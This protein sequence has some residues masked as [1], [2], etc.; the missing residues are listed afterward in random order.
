LRNNILVLGS[1]AFD[2]IMQ[3]NDLFLNQIVS[4]NKTNMQMAL[5]VD[6]HQIRYGG[7]AG[8]ICY[9]LGLLKRHSISISSV[10]KDF[11]QTNYPNILQSKLVDLRFN[12]SENDFTARCYITADT[13]KN[14]IIIFYAGALKNAYKINL[15]RKISQFD[16]IKI[17]INAPNPINAMES[18][19]YQ[20]KRLKIPEIFDPGQQIGQFSQ[21]KLNELVKTIDFLIV[22]EHEFELLRRRLNYTKSKLI[23]QIP[24]LIITLGEKGSILYDNG[25]KSEIGVAK[26]NKIVDPTGAGDGYRSGLLS[27]IVDSI[28]LYDCC[29]VGSVVGSYIV[30]NAGGQGHL[31]DKENFFD[32]F[33]KNFGN[34]P[35]G[36]K[37]F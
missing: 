7:T 1:I 2:Y 9:S 23:S 36:L 14:Q 31:F 28:D 34:L 17:S 26:P 33:E 24:K 20:L 15:F 5:V 35:K 10:G 18:F 29:K 30:E 4:D 37:L 22:N 13:N 27:G 11:F 32:R 12:V 6:S 3:F 8:N 16:N 19:H 25:E 21:E